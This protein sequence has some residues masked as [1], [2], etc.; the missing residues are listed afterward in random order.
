[1]KKAL[2]IF[3]TRPEAI[4]LCPLIVRLQKEREW[5]QSVVCVTGQHREMLDQ[6]LET[7]GVRPD[8]DLDVMKKGQT[9]FDVTTRVLTEARR[10][11]ER[12]KPDILLVQGDTTTTFAASLAAYYLR[13]KVGHVEAGLRSGEKY[14]PFPEELNRRMTSVIADLHFAPTESA[15][16]N[17]LGEGIERD[18]IVVTGS[19]VID[20]LL[21]IKDKIG[22]EKR[23][24]RELEKIDF[25]KKV[26]LVTGH[27]RENFGEEFE[28]VCKALRDIAEGNRDV[29]VVYPV[30][31]NPRVKIPANKLLSGIKN[32]HLLDPLRYEP[33]VFLMC[34]SYL[35]VSDS[36]G[37]QEEAPALG[38]PVLV[39]RSVTERPEGVE[40]GCVRLVGT[41]PERIKLEVN[42]LLRDE[43]SY[44]AMSKGTALYGDGNASVRIIESL[45]QFLIS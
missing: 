2:V 31:L 32:I 19:T 21:W 40:A 37:I 35:I 18:K 33:F 23:T 10:V 17:L 34:E 43:K 25:K 12:E 16:K 28:K 22:R 24:Y 41:D 20:A 27:R 7:F 3:G 8:Y 30:H 9:L 4:K 26:V 38:K 29:E 45:K 15:M 5:I 42:R 36:G 11:L 44:K 1:M 14:F 13:V 39:T 6:F